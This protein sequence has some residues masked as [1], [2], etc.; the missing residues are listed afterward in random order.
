MRNPHLRQSVLFLFVAVFLWVSTATM[1]RAAGVASVSLVAASNVQP[2]PGFNPIASGATIYLGGLATQS[3]SVVANASS[4]GSIVFKL[5]NG[6]YTHTE[7]AVPYT[8]CG[9]SVSSA[10]ACP[11]LD[12]TGS[13]TLTA[14]AYSGS[15]ATGSVLNSIT[16]NFTVASGSALPGPA[17]Y[18]FCA[19]EN[20]TCSFSGTMSVAYGANG[21]F[22]YLTLTGGTPCNNTVFGDPDPGT[23]KA[24]YTKSA[25]T[26]AP[27]VGLSP[28]T[29][30]FTSPAVGT[31]SAVQYGTITNTGNANLVFSGSF[32]VTGSGFAFGGS[33]TCAVNTP[34]APGASCT[35]G[36]VFTPTAAGTST[37]AVTISDNAANS[38]QRIVLTGTGGTTD[39]TPPSTPAGL[40]ASA[41]SS[42][43]INL[44][45]TA[46]TDNVGVT[47]YKIYRNG[48]Q[49]ATSTTT[50]FADSGLAAS[51]AYNYTVAAYDAAGNVS[52]Q[53]AAVS[54]TTEAASPFTK[55]TLVNPV[56]PLSYGA[57]CDGVTDDGAAFQS[58]MNASD[59]LVPAGLT[60]VI[61]STVTVS[62]SN[63]HLECGAGTV[64]K[65]TN[66][67]TQKLFYFTANNGVRLTGDS[68]VN[69]SFIGTNT[70]PP[71]ADWVTLNKHYNIPVETN[72]AVDHFFLAGN[73]F[74]RFWGQAMFQTYGVVDGGTGDVV[75]YNSFKNCAGYGV[76]LVAHTNGYIGHNTAVDC[77]MGVENDNATQN[78]GGN[79]LEFNTL[80]CVNGYGGGGASCTMI[81]GGCAGG[82][83]YTGN[84]V[85]NNSV[86]GVSSGLG[87]NGVL[88]SMIIIGASGGMPAQ[89]SNNSCTGGC[90][91][92]P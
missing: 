43:Q 37:G 14:T 70:I 7:N 63:R 40:S 45:W 48:T 86:S 9:D 79:I 68:V 59:V 41:A 26:P 4:A 23:V 1:A 65:Q 46:S 51:T 24:C 71:Q 27:A 61:N 62:V 52:A 83:N 32:V 53:S 87:P 38:P 29:L 92:N 80:T 12:V 33:G 67:N 25:T 2:I 57:I 18:T 15:S 8:L 66:L 35:V 58:A 22:K 13:H 10:T 60:C 49:V 88:P 31:A 78:T 75:E 91:I 64:L 84:I 81:T 6:A 11:Q 19:N 17:G 54:A 56:S 89:Y 73:T 76:A 5:D 90:V 42:S 16:V 20:Q 82:A 55:P 3:L 85:R 39:T 69:C 50:S 36:I 47:G 72:N 74:D 44:S 77:T 30:S 28:A 34:Y 21:L